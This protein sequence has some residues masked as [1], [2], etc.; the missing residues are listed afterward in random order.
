MKEMKGVKKSSHEGM[1][2]FMRSIRLHDSSSSCL[3]LL[4][5]HLLHQLP[6]SFDMRAL[7]QQRADRHAAHPAP[8]EHRR[9]EIRLAG[10]VDAIDPGLRVAIERLA[11][12][13]GG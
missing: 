2:R 9:R 6:H 10:S 12:E 1:K 3:H 13:A 7:R 8:V 4:H 11:L 5:A